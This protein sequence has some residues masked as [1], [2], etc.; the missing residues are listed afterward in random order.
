MKAYAR[1]LIKLANKY[2]HSA[3]APTPF[4]R[5]R[6]LQILFECGRPSKS[7]TNGGLLRRAHGQRQAEQR[8]GATARIW[9]PTPPHDAS[10][11]GKQYLLE[12]DM[13]EAES[14]PSVIQGR[15]RSTSQ[16][17]QVKSSESA[18]K[19]GVLHTHTLTHHIAFHKKPSDELLVTFL[20]RNLAMPVFVM[21]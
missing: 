16:T 4:G 10:N 21:S 1:K 6:A 8:V 18:R 19:S 20:L 12:E 2:Y 11:P 7:R 5:P 15:P 14:F 3:G 13:Q 17:V 9:S